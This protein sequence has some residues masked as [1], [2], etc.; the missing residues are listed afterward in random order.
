MP[1]N[2]QIL[3]D[4]RPQGEATVD[5]FKLVETATPAL[6]DGEVLVRHHYLSLDPYMRG[7]M[8]DS[9]SYAASQAL[10]EV[11]IGGTVGEV[12]ESRHPK[13][14]PGD[15][16]VGMGGWQLYSVVDGNAP[17]ML[18]KVDT[19]HVPLSYYLGAVGM[20]G[21]TAWY[22][23]VK[24]IQPKAGET[25][26]VS[27]ATGAVGSA[28]AALA[29]ARGC[30]VVGIAGGA[31]KC[32]YATGELGFDACIDY[33]AHPDLKSMAKALKEACPD[34]IDGYFENVG[35]YILDAVLLRANA[36]ARVAVCGMIAGYDGQPL[37]L[38]N[39]ALILIN[40]MKVEGFIVSEHMEVWPEALTE[41]GTL[42]AQGKLRPRES[43]AHGL[44]N[45]PE[46]FLG[47]LKGK[48]F[49]KQLVQLV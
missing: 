15:Q 43:I 10:G 31:E 42:V 25:V 49:G 21:V 40:R 12:V 23:L 29:K 19:T 6:Q 47:L 1:V 35:G 28:F 7:R 14:Q 37:P 18:R 46:A 48:N 36:F 2:Q 38:A 32:A 24:I 3:L 13:F 17:G 20:P 39:P 44:Q 8:N 4:N 22:G 45:A 5:N 41:L 9:K 33:K 11:M 16:V 26:V 34:G 27:A 30:R